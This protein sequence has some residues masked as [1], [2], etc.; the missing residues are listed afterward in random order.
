[1]NRTA[2]AVARHAPTVNIKTQERAASHREASN[3]GTGSE[4]SRAGDR[5]HI[6]RRKRYHLVV[7]TASALIALIGKWALPVHRMAT[8]KRLDAE[9]YAT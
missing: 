7:T 4:S 6:D 2:Q 9:V 3:G 1:M 5:D 8:D